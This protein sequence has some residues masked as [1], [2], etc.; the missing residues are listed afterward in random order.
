MINVIFDMDGTLINSANAISSAVNEIRADLKLAPLEPRF[1][2]QTINTPGKDWAKILY[3]RD[4][5]EHS[6]FKDGFERY[7]IKHYEQSTLLYDGVLEML[8]FLKNKNCYLAIATN[9]PQSSLTQILSKY[10]I[11]PFFSK[12]LGVSLGIEPKPHPMMLKLIVEEAPFEKSVFVGDSD[13]DKQAAQNANIPYF[14]AK[15]GEERCQ[16][17]EF[18]N[19]DELI[20]LLHTQMKA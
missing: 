3:D 12:V 15:W 13:K 17:G 4:E 8:A 5:F 7:F 6:S 10:N 2:I 9:A 1:I 14:H 19:A 18:K 11:L 16:K 20:E